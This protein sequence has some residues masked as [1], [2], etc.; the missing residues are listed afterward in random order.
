MEFRL[1]GPLEVRRDAAPVAIGGPRVRG[2]LAVLLLQHGRPVPRERL[3]DQLWG[4]EPPA[5]T[6]AALHYLVHRLRRALANGDDQPLTTTP[7]GYQLRIQPGSLDLDRVTTLIT[8][9]RAA[10]AAGRLPDAAGQLT[11][12]L[13][14]WR[15]TPLA[16]LPPTPFLDAEATRLDRLHAATV[17]DRA[18]VELA[19]GRHTE[20][21]GEL[22][23]VTRVWPLRERLRAQL[24]LALYRSGR[25][26]EALDVYRDARTTLVDQLGIEPGPEL[27]RLQQ[28]VLNGDPSLDH[29]P[30]PP[31]PVVVPPPPE[32]VTREE[33]KVVTVLVASA[34]SGPEDDPEDARARLG[35]WERRVR[36]EVGRFGGT[37]TAVAGAT[38]MAVFG[39]PVA[40]ED[41]PERAVRAALA[42]A[43]DGRAGVAHGEALLVHDGNG[44]AVS[45]SVV[46]AAASLRAAAEPGAVMV[47]AA[48]ERATRRAIESA[49][50]GN[51]WFRVVAPRART[52]VRPEPDAT[53]P[54]VEREHE[55]AI[56]GGLL[57]RARRG[58]EPQLV[59]L[60]GP[61]GIGKSRLVHELGRIAEDDPE[62]VAWRHG[63]SPSYGDGVTFWALG[64]IVRAEAGIL[65]TAPPEAAQERLV[66]AVDGAL[67]PDANPAEAAWVVRHLR[68]LA[69]PGDHPDTPEGGGGDRRAEVFAAWRRFLEGLAARRPLVLVLEDL[70]WADD[71]MLDFVDELAEPATA[72]PLLV[73]C[74]ARPELL[75]R[76]PA[77][78]G[79]KRNVTTVSLE[80]LTPDGTGR[81]LDA[82]LPGQPLAP[83]VAAQVVASAGGN[84]LFVEEYVR[85]LRD[86]AGRAELTQHRR[87]P[88]GMDGHYDVALPETV[89]QVITAR[90]DTLDPADKALL[91]DA[92]VLGETGWVGGLAALAG[93]DRTTAMAALLRL[94]R[95]EL[96]RR[97]A[98]STVDRDTEYSFRHG[99]VRDVAYG[100][101]PR[102]RRADRHQR[103]AS[104]I[105]SLTPGRATEQT[106]LLAHHLSQALT[107]ARAAGLP[108]GDLRPRARAALREAG[109]RAR[110]LG[111]HVTAARF[112]EA[113]LAL[114]EP[115]DPDRAE[116]LL[117]LGVARLRS[118]NSGLE[119][120]EA[121][122]DAF[123]AAGRA[124]DAAVAEVYMISTVWRAGRTEEVRPRIERALAM[125]AGEPPSRAKAEVLSM[126]ATMLRNLEEDERALAVAQEAVAIGKELG[127]AEFEGLALTTIGSLKGEVGD[128]SGVTDLR[129]AI[130]LLEKVHSGYHWFSL[131]HL[132]VVLCRTGDLPACFEVAAEGRRASERTGISDFDR[133][134]SEIERA[135]EFC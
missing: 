119:V 60:V 55:L 96:L 18:D 66:A 36:D 77:W 28:A 43:G 3:A 79:G 8:S 125:I 6:R 122:R 129:R 117:R 130:A 63:H 70:H 132:G 76:R 124:S 121:A 93:V 94:E 33:R 78:G 45:G 31:A 37:L 40:H 128:V 23:A 53:V 115:G 114:E 41:D 48:I 72:V 134:W 69:V 71:A 39:T 82:L 108:T 9:A 92:A 74:T 84:P 61:P 99:L 25:Q 62:L 67:G 14:L 88:Q 87:Q 91:Q 131:T 127:L 81:L 47:G 34:E 102:A 103:A 98:G 10:R 111:G 80:P 59:T 100:Q 13:A 46:D 86:Q 112:Y 42:I 19:L 17:E 97:S 89:G 30:P 35:D 64:E 15:G 58:G 26:A 109:D 110:A 118:D 106:E 12:A 24:M 83:A 75:E 52:G 113:A 1:L 2:L 90:L 38:A 11:A 49:A 56:L 21:V 133:R 104:W 73:V 68:P 27:A 105:E 101:L 32:P 135:F 116:L 65:V 7:A 44:L 85:M 50:A 29:V 126:G 120:L 51:G 57:D 16:E 5:D 4:D 95:R 107:Y 54:L 22:Q 123:T 20:L